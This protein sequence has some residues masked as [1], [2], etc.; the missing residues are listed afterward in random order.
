MEIQGSKIIKYKGVLV[1]VYPNGDIFSMD[2]SYNV[3]RSINGSGVWHRKGAMLKPRKDKDGY[4]RIRL[5]N[6]GKRFFV[7]VHRLVAMAFIP[8]SNN[9]PCI[10]HKDECKTNNVVSNLEWCSEAYNNHYND[11]YSRIK[12][13]DKPVAKY[14]DGVLIAEY[15]SIKEAAASVNGN[16]SNIGS[17]A[18]NR[19]LSA[20]GYRWKFINQ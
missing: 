18:H 17:R 14:R 5:N 3:A 19:P 16:P 2:K 1:E 10:N 4:L 12:R 9:P 8:N 20:Y 6:N 7:L 15:K 13:N 11:R